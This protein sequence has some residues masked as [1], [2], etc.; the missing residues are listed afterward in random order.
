MK[1]LLAKFSEMDENRDGLVDLQEFA[2]YLRLPVT[3]H[4]EE[5]FSLYDRVCISSRELITRVN[6]LF[7]AFFPFLLLLLLFGS[8]F[9][10]SCFPG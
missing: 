9:S 6:S 3:K 5:L 4:V 10:V 8:G 2:K 7:I 1:D